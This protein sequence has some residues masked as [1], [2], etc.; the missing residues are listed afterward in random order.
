[1]GLSLRTGP[2]RLMNLTGIIIGPYRPEHPQLAGF[3]WTRHPLH[4]FG[5]PIS[6]LMKIV[7]YCV[8]PLTRD[9]Y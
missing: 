8:L 1:M 7:F 3:D 6:D 4:F 5:Y 9:T 2:K